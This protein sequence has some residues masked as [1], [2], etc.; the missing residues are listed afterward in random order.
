MAKRHRKLKQR[1]AAAVKLQIGAATQRAF[2]L[3]QDFA[4][5]RMV[6]GEIAQFEMA[7]IH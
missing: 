7:Q 4:G 5:S 3:Q 2:D 6:R 1:M